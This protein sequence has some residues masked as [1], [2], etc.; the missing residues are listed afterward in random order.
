M[1]TEEDREK[2]EQILARFSDG[3][4]SEHDARALLIALVGDE[5]LVDAAI[6]ISKGIGDVV[7]VDEG[8]DEEDEDEE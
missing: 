6:Q 5:A 2:W 1:I 3:E 4:I 7:E 8:D